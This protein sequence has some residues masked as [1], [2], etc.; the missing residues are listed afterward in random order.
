MLAETAVFVAETGYGSTRAH[1]SARPLGERA[2]NL[3]RSKRNIADH[4]NTKPIEK[5]FIV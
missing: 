3:A 5:I 2:E 1:F 4:R